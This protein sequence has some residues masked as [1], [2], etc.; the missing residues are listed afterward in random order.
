MNEGTNSRYL[1]LLAVMAIACLIW[2]GSNQDQSRATAASAVPMELG[3]GGF[4]AHVL[5]SEGRAPRVL[6][7]DGQRQ[8]LAVYEIGREKGEVKFVSSRNLSYDL[9]MMGFNT[10]KPL[11]EEIKKQ[12]QMH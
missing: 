5:E 12:L 11:P 9:Q 7:I 8:V 2:S 6:F 3:G 10:A 1:G 4:V